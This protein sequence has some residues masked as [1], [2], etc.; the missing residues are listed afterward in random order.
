MWPIVWHCA[1]DRLLSWQREVEESDR[2]AFIIYLRETENYRLNGWA[3]TYRRGFWMS[4]S[5]SFN[6]IRMISIF[7]TQK[8]QQEKWWKFQRTCPIWP[9]DWDRFHGTTDRKF[10]GPSRG[11]SFASRACVNVEFPP[12]QYGMCIWIRIPKIFNEG[13]RNIWFSL[14]TRDRQIKNLC[15]GLAKFGTGTRQLG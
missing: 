11:P 7:S 13:S 15:S 10:H 14:Q 6:L 2:R 12:V 1:V 9:I 5:I 3:E 8:G 4:T